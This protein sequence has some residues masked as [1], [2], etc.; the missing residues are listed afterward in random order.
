MPTGQAPYNRWSDPYLW[1]AVVAILV[2]V[3]D[4]TVIWLPSWTIGCVA[5][6]YTLCV[7]WLRRRGRYIQASNGWLRTR[8]WRSRLQVALVI[9]LVV[10]T[11]NGSQ[12]PARVA[13]GAL[14]VCACIWT[15]WDRQ[16]YERVKAGRQ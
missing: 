13:T 6:G 11:W 15:V 12:W 16:D 9:A 14:L 7:A 10:M 4:S 2:A 1:L 5:V 8:V 3:I